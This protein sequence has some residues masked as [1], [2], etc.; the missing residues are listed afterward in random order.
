[1]CVCVR[2][3]IRKKGCEAK[4]MPPNRCEKI[5][6]FSMCKIHIHKLANTCAITFVYLDQNL[7]NGRLS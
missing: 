5:D 2:D 3:L 6:S 7:P 4:Q 1:M